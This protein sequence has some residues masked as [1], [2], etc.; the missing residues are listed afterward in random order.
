[1]RTIKESS[2]QDKLTHWGSDK[3]LFQQITKPHIEQRFSYYKKWDS[4]IT[5]QLYLP[6]TWSFLL[7]NY[8]AIFLLKR[9]IL[10]F[11]FGGIIK[12]TKC[13]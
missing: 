2:K 1:M 4:I 13:D 3:N 8:I 9:R 12:S 11:I 6:L 5:L 7:E 10:L